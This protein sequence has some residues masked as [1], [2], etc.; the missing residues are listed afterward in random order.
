MADDECPPI[1][2]NAAPKGHSRLRPVLQKQKAN[3]RDREKCRRN[4]K[5]PRRLGA[6]AAFNYAT[7][8][9]TQTP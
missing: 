5:T 9:V 2:P 3:H 7:L 1:W 8:R 4:E 6:D